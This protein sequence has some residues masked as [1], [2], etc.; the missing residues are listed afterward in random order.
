MSAP[1]IFFD[2]TGENSDGFI[3]YYPNSGHWTPAE[4]PTAFTQ[5]LK[6]FLK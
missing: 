2:I 5:D 6:Q 4:E 1:I 3:K